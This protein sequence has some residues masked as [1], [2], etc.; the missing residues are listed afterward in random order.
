MKRKLDRLD[1]A[2]TVLIGLVA[3]A[4]AA[5]LIIFVV[6]VWKEGTTARTIITRDGSQSY[7]CTISDISPNPHDCKP[8]KDAK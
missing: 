2:E 6:C 1:I 4:V 8:I 7:A 3:V 5:I